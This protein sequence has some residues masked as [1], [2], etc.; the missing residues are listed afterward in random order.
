MLHGFELLSTRKVDEIVNVEALEIAF[1]LELPP[2][3]KLFVNTFNLGEGYPLKSEEYLDPESNEKYYCAGALYYPLKDNEKWHLSVSYFYDIEQILNDW[4]T[5]IKNEKEWEEFGFLRIAGIGQGGGLFVG[6]RYENR[7]MIY[8][9]VWDWEE[10]YFK[11][12]DNIFDLMKGFAYTD[13]ENLQT[14]VSKNQL[15][16]NWGDNFWQVRER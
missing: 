3:Y 6:T 16:K 4:Q 9:V 7:D 10:P 5:Y 13:D 2:L 1:G 11:V 8:E 15:Y 14:G 12:A